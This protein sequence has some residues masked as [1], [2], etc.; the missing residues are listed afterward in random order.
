M[1]ARVELCIMPL[2]PWNLLPTVSTVANALCGAAQ[3]L[4]NDRGDTC[5]DL[6]TTSTLKIKVR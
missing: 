1:A 4:Y 2:T 3:Q 5:E 6:P